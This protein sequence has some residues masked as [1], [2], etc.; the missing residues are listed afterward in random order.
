MLRLNYI[1]VAS[2]IIAFCNSLAI[3]DKVNKKCA[4]SDSE[5]IKSLYKSFIQ[6]ASDNGIEEFGV[7]KADPFVIKNMEVEALGMIKITAKEGEITGFR[8]CEL[9]DSKVDLTALRHSVSIFCDRIAVESSYKIESTPTLLALIGGIDVHGEGQGGAVFEKITLNLD[10]AF[11]LKK[12]DDGEVYIEIKPDDTT[13]SFEVTGKATVHADNIYVGKQ[14]ISTVLV[15]IFNENWEFLTNNFGKTVIDNASGILME[16]AQNLM[17]KIPIK[18][19]I[20]DDVS[21]YVKS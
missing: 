7:P 21:P 20:T 3:I 6:E 14:E 2:A 15:N 13:Y 18:N 16:H 9:T 19:L 10:F 1:L 12:R 4:S 11:D 8:N 5:C 17:N